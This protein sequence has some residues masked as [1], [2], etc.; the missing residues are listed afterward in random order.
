[1][2]VDEAANKGASKSCTN[3]AGLSALEHVCVCQ[4]ILTRDIR[5]FDL[6]FLLFKHSFRLM[7]YVQKSCGW[8]DYI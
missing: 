7:M 3:E 1:M 6:L 5:I 4:K 2:A 8:V